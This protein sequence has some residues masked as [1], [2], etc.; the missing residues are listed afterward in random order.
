MAAYQIVSLVFSRE[1]VQLD[2]VHEVVDDDVFD[3]RRARLDGTVIVVRRQQPDG[4]Q[5]RLDLLLEGGQLG[6]RVQAEVG[7]RRRRG[8]AADGTRRL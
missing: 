5:D 4:A 8:A 2:N 3:R 6:V 7:H 1:V